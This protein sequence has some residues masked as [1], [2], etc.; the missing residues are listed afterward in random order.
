MHILS[1]I[2]SVASTGN[3]VTRSW[4]VRTFF[5]GGWGGI[6]G[7]LGFLEFFVHLERPSMTAAV[8]GAC[9]VSRRGVRKHPLLSSLTH[10]DNPPPHSRAS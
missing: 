9:N 6:F 8:L 3:Q 10:P 4:M 1:F 2:T 5:G 7:P